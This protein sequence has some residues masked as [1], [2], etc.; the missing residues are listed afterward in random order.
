M[1]NAIDIAVIL[2][3]IAELAGLAT[4]AVAAGAEVSQED[5][6]AAFERA[7]LAD[8]AWLASIVAPRS[9]QPPGAPPP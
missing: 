1:S 7:G 3:I 4:R 6:E 9:P 8:E 5:L 2:R